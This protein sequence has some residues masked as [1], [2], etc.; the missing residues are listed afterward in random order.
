MPRPIIAL[1]ASVGLAALGFAV[2]RHRSLSPRE[3]TLSGRVHWV[4]DG[5]TIIVDG[6]GTVRYLGIDTPEL[7]H[8]RKP[9]QRYARE[10]RRAN[11]RLVGGRTVSLVTDRERRDKYGRL[12]AYVYVDGDMANAALVCEGMARTL[13]FWPNFRFANMFERMRADAERRRIGLWSSAQGGLPWGDPLP[14]VLHA[15]GPGPIC[16]RRALR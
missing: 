2:A 4:V 7:H 13:P 15:A 12:L 5:D 9:L 8:P 14:S 3:A 1:I 10:A 11:L 16:Q 6:V